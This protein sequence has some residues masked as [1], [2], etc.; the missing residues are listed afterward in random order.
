MTDN[1]RS[2]G[3]VLFDAQ[4]QFCSAFAQRLGPLLRRHGFALAPLQTPWVK[5]KLK[6]SD[7][8]LLSE[9]RLLTCKG[10]IYGGADALIA[11]ARQIWWAW[12]LYLLS[13]IP[14][15]KPALA[16]AYRWIARRRN[17]VTRYCR[18]G[19]TPP[20]KG[21]H[22]GCRSRRVFFEMP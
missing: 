4:C 2:K 16:T 7:E 6:L 11:I 5:E 14:L 20:A 17:C 9:M 8:D 18:A 21:G 1:T 3:W 10:E 13:R 15:V 12:P 19:D 22:K